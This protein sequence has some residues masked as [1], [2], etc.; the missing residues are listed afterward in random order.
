M[1][2]QA[3]QMYQQNIKLGSITDDIKLEDIQ[4][5]SNPQVTTQPQSR[6][7]IGIKDLIDDGVGDDEDLIDPMD[8]QILKP[9]HNQF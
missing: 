3:P 9:R 1:L 5:L 4:N 8:E 6:N 7:L 2:P